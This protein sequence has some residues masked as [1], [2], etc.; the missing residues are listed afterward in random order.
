MTDDFD[1]E[2]N[3]HLA[4]LD[5][6][7]DRTVLPG[8]SAARR[9]AAQRTRHQVTGGL[10]AG[11]AV[12]AVGA[13]TVIQPTF[14]SAPAPAHSPSGTESVTVAPTTPTDAPSDD[15]SPNPS[16][17]PSGDPTGDDEA[18]VPENALLTAKDL[19][20]D[21][22]VIWHLI[23]P[24]EAP[25]D[26]APATPEGAAEVHFASS[27]G[28]Q[29]DEFV[30]MTDSPEQ[31][32]T[33][34]TAQ[35]KECVELGSQSDDS[36]HLDQIWTVDNV[37]D[38]AWIARYMVPDDVP[39][40]TRIVTVQIARTGDHLMA[41][42]DSWYA[43]DANF[44]PELHRIVAGAERLC[45]ALDTTCVNAPAL[46]DRLHPVVEAD[47][48]GWLTVAD[49]VA[50][51]GL[52]QITESAWATVEDE[53][54]WNYIGLPLDPTADGATSLE[55]RSYF[56]PL[57]PG[58]VTL[59]ETVARFDDDTAA[60][61]HYDDLVAAADV[62]QQE[63]DVV[64]NTGTVSGDGFEATSWRSENAEFGSVF[65]YGVVV[66][67]DA[68]AVVVHSPADTMS[69]DRMNALLRAAGTH[70]GEL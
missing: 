64:T 27:E 63:G 66:R 40:A 58:S 65:V 6:D 46:G 60:R 70:L 9:R 41:L 43:Q 13:L 35:V 10:L 19:A 50:A 1:D 36:Y 68:V 62:S 51:T 17:D 11:V 33:N 22:G 5:S 23:T 24:P 2:L 61:S 45:A 18:A 28:S 12:V 4:S 55:R 25:L 44:P 14:T 59:E 56:D 20:G 47:A 38:E 34:T 8:A 69:A 54:G 21:T 16:G 48:P 26:C 53:L 52:G 37:G 67:G 7:L 39:E 31:R 29:F 57:D 42:T 49:V 15:P 3:R 32:F 30:E